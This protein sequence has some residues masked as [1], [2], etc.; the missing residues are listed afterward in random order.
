MDWLKSIIQSL[1]LDKISDILGEIVIWWSQMV[2]DVPPADLPMYAYIGGSVVVLVL[3][4]LVARVLP[5]PLGGITWVAIFAIL[6]TPGHALDDPSVLAPASISVVYAVLMKD[7]PAAIANAVPVLGVFVVG[8]FMGFI[9]QLIRGVFA[10]SMDA[11]RRR[12]ADD[13]V[14]NMQFAG[15]NYIAEKTDDVPVV[16]EKTPKTPAAKPEVNLVKDSSAKDKVK[17]KAKAKG[18]DDTDQTL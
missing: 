15:G 14:A 4:I 2:K 8:L 10:V 3:W 11:A 12:T 16:L 9:W 1:P 7:I 13:T 6:F 18:K 17:A 5:R